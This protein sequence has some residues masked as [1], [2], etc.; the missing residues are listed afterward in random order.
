M[1][2]QKRTAPD[3]EKLREDFHQ[4]Y[5]TGFD[6]EGAT[7]IEVVV[8]TAN[9]LAELVGPDPVN[10][11]FAELTRTLGYEFADDAQW[12]DALREQASGDAYCWPIGERLHDLNAY[13]Y[14]G[15]ALNGGRTAAERE[16][17][18]RREIETVVA[19]MGK[20]P[21]AAWGIDP[22]DA[23]RTLSRAQARF[24]LDTEK[25]IEPVAL[26]KLGKVTERRIRNMMAGK[27][28]VFDP[29]DGRIRASEALSWL[30]NRTDSFRPS[31][32]RDQNTF[33][34]LVEHTIEIE[35]AVFVPV[36]S[37]NTFF[38]PG[39]ARD[40]QFTVGRGKREQ[41]F[42]S[43]EAALAALQKFDAPAWS[44]PTA[45]GTWT[46]VNAVRW[47]RMDRADLKSS[48]QERLTFKPRRRPNDRHFHPQSCAAAGSA[49]PLPQ[50]P[51]ATGKQGG[52]H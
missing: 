37:D 6:F 1:P 10:A 20:V 3:P 24:D 16:K 45:N 38:H 22:G 50:R 44:R 26:A 7:L 8:G 42:D 13:A 25:D 2:K 36:A 4:L 30:K 23:G 47:A 32:W 19:F 48:R 29:R 46:T 35:N 43:Y 12:A 40:G 34:D 52:P 33:D 15:I 31:C 18:L 27:E 41:K 21:F 49:Q 5:G 14:Y 11:A 28:R 51:A 9:F 39:L 17:L